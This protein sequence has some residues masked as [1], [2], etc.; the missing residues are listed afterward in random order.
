MVEGRASGI[1]T[2]DPDPNDGGVPVGLAL[3]GFVFAEVLV[4]EEI[5][6]PYLV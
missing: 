2:P 6:T 3:V 5:F 4:D 1:P